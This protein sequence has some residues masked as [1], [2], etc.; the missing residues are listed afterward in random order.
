[1][2]ASSLHVL[3]FEKVGRGDVAKVGGKNAS[4]GEMVANLGGKGVRVPPGFATTADAY[5]HF[6]EANGLKQSITDALGDLA[7]GKATLAET[8]A[9]I[10]RMF[11]RGEWPPETAEA[12]RAAYRRALQA[13]GQG[14]SR[15][16]GALE[17]HG[18]G[19]ARRQLRRPAG[20]LS[21]H[22]RR[23]RAA[24]RLPALLRLALHRPRHQLPPGQGLRPH[25]GRAVDRRAAHGALRSRRRR[26][27][28]LDRHRDRLR[29]GRADQR[30][31]GPGR[32]RRAG[33]RRSRRIRGVQAAAGGHRAHADHREEAAARRRRR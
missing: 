4:L 9:S 5:W 20:D 17:R 32:E 2:S 3:W 13:R 14:G 28:V 22:P 21:Q 8:G 19:P 16:R 29:Q 24:R 7:A 1:M 23:R 11:L 10:R 31:L 26:R 30:R 25:E 33:R 6:V 27:H 12:I 18:R 15:C